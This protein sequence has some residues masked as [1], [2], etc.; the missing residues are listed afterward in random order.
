M[1][2]REAQAL[3]QEGMAALRA[4]RADEALARIGALAAAE[5]GNPNVL[6]GLALAG[7][8]A[9][10]LEGA[11]GAAERALAADRDNLRALL[12]KADVLADMKSHRAAARHY[13]ELVTRVSDPARLPPDLAVEWPRVTAAQERLLAAM[14]DHAHAVVRDA[15][16]VDGASSARFG[17]ALG[18]LMGTAKRY[19]QEPRIFYFPGL[20]ARPFFDPG[21]FAWAAEVEGATAAIQAE[22]APLMTRPEVW[23]PYLETD[24]RLVTDRTKALVDSTDWSACYLW[25][26][27]APVAEIAQAAPRTMVALE[28][29]PLEAIPGRSPFA[30]FSK[31]SPG[32][33][34]EPHTGFMNTRLVCHLPLVVPEGCSFRV[35]NE[36]RGWET[37]KLMVFDDTIEHEARNAGNEERVVLIFN[38]WRPEL[39]AEERGLV[40]ALIAGIGQFDEVH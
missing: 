36:T 24:Q 3:W 12:V 11:L 22:L 26:D 19:E 34:I 16:F 17:E 1:D 33:W 38:I 32:A 39:S 20:V 5:P 27:G 18:I 25:R 40:S 4:G 29:V 28:A 14:L 6:V 10:D 21:S 23:R 15:G 9:G 8:A 13:R 7:R 2:R 37:G 35:G 30:L 31:L